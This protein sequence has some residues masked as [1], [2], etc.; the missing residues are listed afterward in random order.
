MAAL[1]EAGALEVGPGL[2]VRAEGSAFTAESPCVPGSAVTVTTLVEARLPHS[3]LRRTDDAL[4][5]GLLRAGAC[6][7][8]RVGGHDTGGL[9]VTATPHYLMD[10]QESVRKRP[11][12]LGIPTEGVHW[13][14]AAGARPG[15]G[16]VTLADAYAVARGALRA[17]VPATPPAPAPAVAGPRKRSNVELASTH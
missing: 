6:R 2:R 5:G 16:S 15:V 9:D 4:L 17:A 14:T 8:H 12:A 7:T 1:I 11:L 13:V 10:R 3:D